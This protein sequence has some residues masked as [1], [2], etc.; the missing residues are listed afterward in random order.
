MAESHVCFRIPLKDWNV[1]SNE[2]TRAIVSKP[3]LVIYSIRPK[4][5]QLFS[6][7]EENTC[8]IPMPCIMQLKFTVIFVLRKEREKF[9]FLLYM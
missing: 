6:S 3:I 9:I 1:S 2:L 7:V 5:E 8:S 4:K